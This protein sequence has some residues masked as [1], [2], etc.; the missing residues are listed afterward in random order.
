MAGYIGDV[1]ELRSIIM[2]QKHLKRILDFTIALL[3]LL[4]L[5][6][7]LL[8]V[9]I[10]LHFANEGAGVFFTQE[11]PGKDGKLFK[12]IKFKSMTE[13]RDASGQLLPDSERLT[14]AGRFI[15]KTSIDELPEL[16]NVLN[17]DMSLIEIGRAHV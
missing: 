2:Y 5:M 11:R 4:V 15:R 3:A 6:P 1:S 8:I 10:W 17:G 14:T 13:R 7:L 16:F 12:I 9:I